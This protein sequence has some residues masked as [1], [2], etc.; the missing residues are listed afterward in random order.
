MIATHVREPIFDERAQDVKCLKGSC[1][2]S[3]HIS[4][5]E[6]SKIY[7][8]YFENKKSKVTLEDFYGLQDHIKETGVS[9]RQKARPYLWA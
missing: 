8:E 3:E 9:P 4:V 7:D 2:P 5:E 1:E 6:K